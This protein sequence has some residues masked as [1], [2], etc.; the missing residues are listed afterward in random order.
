MR[1]RSKIAEGFANF[2]KNTGTKHPHDNFNGTLTSSLMRRSPEPLTVS[3]PLDE[4]DDFVWT[5]EVS[6]GTPA[7]TFPGT[8]LQ[9]HG[10]NLN[11]MI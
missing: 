3:L 5:G 4:V 2:E 6:V 7:Q 1:K 9:L 10:C 11:P 8:P